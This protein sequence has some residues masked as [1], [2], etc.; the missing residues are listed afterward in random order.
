MYLYC[1]FGL[2]LCFHKIIFR[3]FFG[4]LGFF[5]SAIGFILFYWYISWTENYVWDILFFIYTTYVSVMTIVNLMNKVAQNDSLWSMCC[6]VYTAYKVFFYFAD[7][8]LYWI[9]YYSWIKIV[10]IVWLLLPSKSGGDLIKF[11]YSTRKT[12]CKS[13]QFFFSNFEIT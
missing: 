3:T 9:P 7:S 5:K 13:L 10:L 11:S 1:N 12:L 2:K 8:Y 6:T 4:D